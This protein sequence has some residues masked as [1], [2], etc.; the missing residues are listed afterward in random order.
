MLKQ[1]TVLAPVT[2]TGGIESLICHEP[3]FYIFIYAQQVFTVL[4]SSYYRFTTLLNVLQNTSSNEMA[5]ATTKYDTSFHFFS[6]ILKASIFP[7]S[8]CDTGLNLDT[9]T[10]LQLHTFHTQGFI[11][12]AG[13][14]RIPC[15]SVDCNIHLVSDDSQLSLIHI[16]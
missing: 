14:S 6:Q 15:D 11:I 3:Q 13:C 16:V 8:S 4:L 7:T 10:H 12:N 2:C 9:L 5:Q 1:P